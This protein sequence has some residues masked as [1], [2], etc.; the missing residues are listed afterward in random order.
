MGLKVGDVGIDFSG[1]DLQAKRIRHDGGLFMLRYSAGAG[2]HD[3]KAQFKLCKPGEIDTAVTAGV[4]FIANSEWYETRITEGGAAGRADGQADLAF[5]KSR[6]LNK[7]AAIYVS[8][9]DTPRPGKWALAD[10][11]LEAYN[12][13]LGGYYAVDAY[14]GTSYLSHALGKG[15]IRF[16]WRPNAGSWSNDGLP[17]Q[18]AHQGRQHVAQAQGATPAA[19][20][21]TGNYWYGKGA[22][23]NILL[24]AACG[25]HLQATGHPVPHHDS[26]PDGPTLRRPWPAW[27]P[28]GDYFGLITGPARSHGGIDDRERKSVRAIQ[29]RLVTLKMVPGVDDVNSGW[30]DG[31][32][33]KPTAKA[34]TRWQQEHMPDTEFFGQVWP[35]DWAKLFTF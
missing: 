14:A 25:S 18:P 21:Q 4:D 35:D 22:D 29:A 15:L 9:D 8:W 6:G 12:G 32:F 30:C 11:Y 19:I 20:W 26:T 27:V 1:A 16:G 23:E 28:H 2:R 34:V 5:W 24:R 13:A 33:E 7:G 10:A 17:Y 31:R 3:P